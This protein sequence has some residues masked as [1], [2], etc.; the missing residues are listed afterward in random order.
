MVGRN[1][2]PSGSPVVV[3]PIVSEEKLNEVL[4]L[5]TEY[6]DLDFKQLLDLTTAEGAVELAKDVGAMQVEG[7]Y[8][9]VG[10]DD[11][12]KPVD[13]L[14]DINLQTFDEANLTQKL[15][16]YLPEP[17]L[18]H[19]QRFERDGN[20]VVLI[21]VGRHPA[22]CAIFKADG[23][24]EKDGSTVVRFRA[25]EVF[26]RDGTRSVRISQRGF[27]TIV[28][29]RIADA[30]ESWREEQQAIRRDDFRELRLAFE[31]RQLTDAPLGA[32]NFDL[33]ISTLTTSALELLR[34]PDPIALQHLLNDSLRRARLIAAQEDFESELGEL[35]DKLVCLAVTLLEHE[36]RDWFDRVIGTLAQIY[37]FGFGE[38]ATLLDYATQL[39]PQEKGPRL[40]LLVISP[41]YALGG[42]AAR[43]QD[44]SAIKTLTL[45]HPPGMDDYYPNWLRHAL[46]MAARARHLEE[47]QGEQRVQI[48][49]L[50]LARVQV[51]RLECLRSDGLASDSDEILTSLTQFDILSNLTAIAA[52]NSVDSS[53]FFPNWARFY[54]HRVVPIVERLLSDPEMRNILFPLDDDD[55]AIALN[56]MSRT[57]REE[58]GRYNGFWG[59]GRTGVGE[60]LAARPPPTQE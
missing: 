16:R 9:V 40:W 4:G 55:L 17:L 14:A 49:L 56:A 6:A 21:Y 25:G 10:V 43:R 3:E 24:Y 22:G 46:T 13:G 53:V 7:G 20:A 35:V 8:I 30:K 19:T 37:G 2:T 15:G 31:S 52:A 50:S 11:Q 29:G 47:Q 42:L 26:W 27:E 28:E 5:E 36:Q 44:W 54:S 18:L 57:A 41:I 48:S 59:W 45:Q 51:E 58:G 60:W 23:K 33:D 32:V 1:E 39:S 12:G 38:N 34:K